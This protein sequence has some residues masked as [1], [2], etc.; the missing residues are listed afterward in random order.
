MTIQTEVT[1]RDVDVSETLRAA[2]VDRA[3]RLERFAGDILSC[4]VTVEHDAAH[5]QQGNPFRIHARV[6]MRGKQIDVSGTFKTKSRGEDAYTAVADTFD[7]LRR[8]IEDYVR[9]RR[10][11]V[12]RARAA[13]EA[14][15]A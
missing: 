4:R 8:R 14:A 3:Q 13:S 11:D 5:R 10:G 12:K 9:R 1:F 7:V 6:S 15:S 2:I